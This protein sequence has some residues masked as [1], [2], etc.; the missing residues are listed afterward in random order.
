MLQI[1][2]NTVDKNKYKYTVKEYSDAICLQCITGTPSTNNCIKYVE[3]NLIP[4]C[5]ITKA[6]LSCTED[7]CKTN[8]DSLKGRTT[9]K[10]PDHVT[11]SEGLYKSLLE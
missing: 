10:I 4:N 9:I 5:P 1:L 8:I 3:D 11:I 2:I 7:I 6:N